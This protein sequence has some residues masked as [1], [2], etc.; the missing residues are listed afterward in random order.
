MLSF[1]FGSVAYPVFAFLG[2]VSALIWFDFLDAVF[3]IA[4]CAVLFILL[5]L[6]ILFVLLLCYTN[7]APPS[8]FF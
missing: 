6:Q 8:S 1:D 7:R 5:G 4:R 2:L 3:C